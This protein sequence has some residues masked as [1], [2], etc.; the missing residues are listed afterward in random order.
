MWWRG[1]DALRHPAVSVW[2][3][4]RE[5]LEP[6]PNE[7]EDTSR[8]EEEFG[9]WWREVFT[10]CLCVFVCVSVSVSECVCVCV[11]VFV[12]THICRQ[13]RRNTGYFLDFSSRIRLFTLS[14]TEHS[15]RIFTPSYTDILSAHTCFFS[16]VLATE[17]EEGG[18]RGRAVIFPCPIF[19]RPGTSHFGFY[20][21]HV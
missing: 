12:C 7:E 3:W 15:L 16:V 4:L 2:S 11:C 14:Y 21:G 17:R 5:V 20:S 18:G 6:E 13:T 8:V 10:P 9:V 1:G 19:P